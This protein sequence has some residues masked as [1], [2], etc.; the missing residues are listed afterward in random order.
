[1]RWPRRKS[2][3]LPR[4]DRA[5]AS[6]SRAPREA[7]GSS[8]LTLVGPGTGALKRQLAARATSAHVKPRR[9]TCPATWAT[10][11]TIDRPRPCST[12]SSGPALRAKRPSVRSSTSIPRVAAPSQDRRLKPP[13]VRIERRSSPAHSSRAGPCHPASRG[14]LPQPPPMPGPASG[15]RRSPCGGPDICREHRVGGSSGTR[16]VP[17]RRGSR[18]RDTCLRTLNVGHEDSSVG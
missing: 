18:S 3:A 10:A 15:R 6:G 14:P 17:D 1:M 11:S 5:N 13:V 16:A 9:R 2:V 4:P 7:G 8:P 12:A